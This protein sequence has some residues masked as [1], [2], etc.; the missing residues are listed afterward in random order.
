M[1]RNR[2]MRPKQH[3]V[4]LMHWTRWSEKT[5]QRKRAKGH[6]W[7][8][9]IFLCVRRR[10]FSIYLLLISCGVSHLFFIHFLL[11]HWC[12]LWRLSW[13]FNCQRLQPFNAHWLP[14]S[15]PS[16]DACCEIDKNKNWCIAFAMNE[17]ERQS[18]IK[19]NGGLKRCWMNSPID[20]WNTISAMPTEWQQCDY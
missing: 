18:S 4:L 5:I 20:I 13:F 11:G 1:W 8:L 9:I 16:C 7:N 10:R 14:V 12:E 3:N 19:W 2:N 6:E 15:D 17:P